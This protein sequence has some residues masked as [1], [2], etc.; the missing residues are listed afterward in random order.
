MFGDKRSKEDEAKLAKEIELQK[1]QIKKE[2]VDLIVRICIY[3]TDLHVF[4]TIVLITGKRN[5]YP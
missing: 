2:D 4:N 1:V 3:F 5:A